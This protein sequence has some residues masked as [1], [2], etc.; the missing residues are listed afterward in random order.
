MKKILLFA[1]IIAIAAAIY[2]MR[3][4]DEAPSR[5]NTENNLETAKQNISVESEIIDIKITDAGYEPNLLTIKI[6]TTVNFKNL[7]SV[8][9]WPAS[10]I[11][12]THQIYPE[13]DPKK[14]IPSG[15]SWSFKFDKAGVW[16]FHDHLFTNLNGIITVEK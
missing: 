11:H 16:R 8:D 12:P 14:A 2:F 5:S 6:G 15:G 7:S 10:G 1:A 13:F 3:D 9:R 4:N